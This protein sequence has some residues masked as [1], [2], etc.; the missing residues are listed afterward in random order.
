MPQDNN[1]RAAGRR[2]LPNDYSNIPRLER[3]SDSFVRI[4]SKL[5]HYRAGSRSF[6]FPGTFAAEARNRGSYNFS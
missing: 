6:P 4:S 2:S 3:R 1:R 5:R